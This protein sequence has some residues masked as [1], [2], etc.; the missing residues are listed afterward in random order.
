VL[1]QNDFNV[2]IGENPG[3][4]NREWEGEI[5]DIAIWN[6]VL[7]AA[8]VATLYNGGREPR[9]ARLPGITCRS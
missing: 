3:A 1:D 8:E 6:R 4:R 9:S 7:T 5:D 2:M